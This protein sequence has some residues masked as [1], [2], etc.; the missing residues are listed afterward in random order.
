MAETELAYDKKQ[1]ATAAGTG[2]ATGGLSGMLAGAGIGATA[3]A[4][5]AG[6]GAIPGAIIGGLIGLAAGA[7][8]GGT[9]AGVKDDA[10]QKAAI[11]AQHLSIVD[12]KNAARD[13]K[14][15]ARLTGAVTP[16]GGPDLL[17]AATASPYSARGY[18]SWHAS[19]WGA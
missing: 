3:G 9:V 17:D 19:T 6:V 5:G 8:V 10:A 1:N 14:L 16:K 11:Q 15:N 2:A 12:A 7:G 18:D 13:A 4:A